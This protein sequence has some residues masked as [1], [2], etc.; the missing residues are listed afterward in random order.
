MK[1]RHTA[2]LLSVAV[3]LTSACATDDPN[4]RAKTGA[5]IGAVAG[6]VVG[7]QAHDENGRFVG[8]AVGA[9][10]GAVVGNYMDKQ[11]RDL[12]NALA[13]ELGANAITVTRVD[14]ETLKL[15]LSSEAT[16]DINS[17]DVKSNFRR[18]LR[19]LASVV[20]Q[21]DKT[22]VH[23]LGHTDSTGTESYNQKLSETRADAVSRA[24]A[25]SG[26]DRSRLRTVGYGESQPVS[27]NDT[28][29][30]RSQNR[31]VEVYLR[32]IVEGR[33]NEAF[34]TPS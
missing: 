5:A 2:V 23:L 12:E 28:K 24:L 33:E 25:A 10:T 30:G 13:L 32:S 8:A 15:D 26:V 6:A 31:R 20:D 27:S 9:L 4:R 18:S 1:I 34:R 11:Q 14:E 17:A 22:A 21:Y 19:K 7:H 16:F 3:A 29:A